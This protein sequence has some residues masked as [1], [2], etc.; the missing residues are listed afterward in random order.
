MTT[1][2]PAPA[3]R[4]QREPVNAPTGN[5]DAIG[6]ECPGAAGQP[7]EE[8]PLLVAVLLARGLSV[9]TAESLTGGLVSAS[10]ASVPGASGTLRGGAVTY[11]THSKA[12]VL[13]V[14]AELLERH[15]PVHPE[16]AAQMARGAAQLFGADVALATTGVAGPGP[17]GGHA[18]GTGFLAV[19]FGNTLPDE[20]LVES[21]AVPGQRNQVRERVS[22]LVMWRARALLCLPR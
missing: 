17:H 8:A 13:G 11:A 7:G 2:T 4:E 6:Q 10:L 12:A 1:D 21:F 3:S 19:H 15:G 16:V 9:A 5:A 18:A 22:A 14:D 20:T